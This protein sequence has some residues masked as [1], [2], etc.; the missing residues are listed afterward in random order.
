NDMSGVISHEPPRILQKIP[1]LVPKVD[2]DGNEIAG[3]QT[4]MHQLPIGTYLGWN[5]VT[6]GFNKGRICAFTG[7]FVPFAK[8]K[9][10]RL[11]SGAPGPSIEERYGSI[12]AFS[13]RAAAAIDRLVARRYLLPADGTRELNN[14]VGDLTKNGLLPP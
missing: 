12:P 10:E 2:A 13:P 11:A 4:L 6:S 7:G 14:A 3:V 1:T 9:A 5:V 8:T